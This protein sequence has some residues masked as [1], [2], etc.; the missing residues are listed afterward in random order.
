[1]KFS[2]FY[3]ST[4]QSP[5][6]IGTT[7]N[8]NPLEAYSIH[9][10]DTPGLNNNHY[11]RIC[12]SWSYSSNEMIIACNQQP[13]AKI[14]GMQYL[15]GSQPTY[16]PLPTY[17][18]G[19]K[20][21]NQNYQSNIS[22]DLVGGPM[23]LVK[24]S[25]SESFVSN[26][27]KVFTFTTPFEWVS[28]K[29]LGITCAWGQSPNNYSYTGTHRVSGVGASPSGSWYDQTDDAGTYSYNSVVS[30]MVTYRPVVQF[31]CAA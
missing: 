2:Q 17:T 8:I 12:F 26:Q 29:A 6:F 15:V 1:M 31:I 20:L 4:K 11:R 22:G 24:A 9:A 10:V 27:V 13:K 25:S 19:M 23:T 3:G 5:S 30:G 14:I 28:G 18:I 16:Q 7:P 21:H